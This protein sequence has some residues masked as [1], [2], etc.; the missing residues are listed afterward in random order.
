MKSDSDTFDDELDEL[1]ALISRRYGRGKG[2]YKGKLLIIY[3]SCNKF[4]HISVRCTD[5]EGIDKRKKR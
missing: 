4:G 1:E 3:F 2:K 5:K